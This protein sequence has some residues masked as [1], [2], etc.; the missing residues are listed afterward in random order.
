MKISLLYLMKVITQEKHVVLNR[1]YSLYIN[2]R[3]FSF[4]KIEPFL[5]ISIGYLK[6]EEKD[7]T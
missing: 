7:I 6:V 3:E 1:N 2:Y 5:S 4:E